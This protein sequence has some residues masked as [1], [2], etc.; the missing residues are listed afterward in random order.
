ME[1]I[2]ASEKLVKD[3]YSLSNTL[4]FTSYSK[5]QAFTDIEVEKLIEE[6]GID[7]MNVLEIEDLGNTDKKPSESPKEKKVNTKYDDDIEEEEDI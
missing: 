3:F 4:D 7:L 2:E 6:D 5:L 1:K